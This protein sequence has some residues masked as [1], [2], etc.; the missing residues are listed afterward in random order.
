MTQRRRSLSWEKKPWAKGIVYDRRENAI[1]IRREADVNKAQ[2]IAC[3]LPAHR[4]TVSI[5]L[6]SNGS[7]VHIRNSSRKNRKTTS[8]EEVFVGVLDLD[9]LTI[10]DKISRFCGNLKTLYIEKGPEDN[11]WGGDK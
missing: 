3:E 8:E 9:T 5:F 4:N 7:E 11:N 6:N 10:K 1:K 2:Y